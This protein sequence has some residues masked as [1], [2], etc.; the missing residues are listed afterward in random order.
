MSKSAYS[1]R[2][3]RDIRIKPDVV[4][5]PK[6]RACAV[7]G[8]EGEGA[9]RVPKSRDQLSAYIWL[10]LAHAREHNEKWDYFAGMSE[11]EIRRFQE[12]AVIGHRPTWPLGKRAAGI[13]GGHGQY[14]IEDGFAFAD[15]LKEAHQPRRPVRVVTRLQRQAFDVLNLDSS[16]TLNEIKA[17][18]KELVK[19]FHPDAN[20]GDRGTEE[21]LKQVIKAYGVL[22]ASGLT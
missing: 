22:R 7:K 15:E 6:T 1:P 2:F 20:G 18:Y 13:P 5:A 19:R 10:C 9:Y 12:E 17:R 11:A 8:C 4:H 3:G 14:H 21:R 16:A